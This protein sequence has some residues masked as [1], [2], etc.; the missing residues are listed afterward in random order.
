MGTTKATKGTTKGTTKTTSDPNPKGKIPSI[1]KATRNQNQKQKPSNVILG[2]VFEKARQQKASPRES[3]SPLGGGTARSSP[4]IDG[5]RSTGGKG[6]IP[7]SGWLG[8]VLDS[9]GIKP[10]L[11]DYEDVPFDDDDSGGCGCGSDGVLG[12]LYDD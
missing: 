7:L 3:K 4:R 5:G 12:D 2:A 6:K 1:A 10:D 8:G 9:I 11:I